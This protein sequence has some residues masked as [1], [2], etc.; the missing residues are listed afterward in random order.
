M[1]RHYMKLSANGRHGSPQ[2]EQTRFG[3]ITAMA[4]RFLPSVGFLILCSGC[5]S[6]PSEITMPPP[7]L[8]T[9]C[10]VLPE[11]ARL[12]PDRLIWEL[13]IVSAYNDC[14]TKHRLTVEAWRALDKKPPT[15]KR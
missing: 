13:S 10:P 11:P 12:D 9:N 7:N 8:A 2:S 1:Y 4:R 3:N 5:S 14:A 6:V 15:N